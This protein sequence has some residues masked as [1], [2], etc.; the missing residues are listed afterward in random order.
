M[1]TF[2]TQIFACNHCNYKMCTYE[3]SSYHVYSSESYSDGYTDYNPPVYFNKEIVICSN[4]KKEMW[5]DDIEFKEGY[6]KDAEGLESS[7]DV[8]DLPLSKEINHTYNIA[9]YYSGLIK[10]GFANTSDREIKLRLEI[11]HLLN[12]NYRY[13]RISIL[14]LL[15]KRN[16]RYASIRFKERNLQSKYDKLALQLFKENLKRLIAIFDTTNDED[17]LLLA[18]MYRENRNFKLA[19]STLLR[20]KDLSSSKPYKKILR[21]IRL[22]RSKVIKLN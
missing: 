1:T 15:L 16:F 3:L 12:N 21:E 11:W 5:R 8:Y 9:E 14:G 19:K 13:G 2:S 10:N 7:K 20:A 18:E 4:C 22:R 17:I 6:Y